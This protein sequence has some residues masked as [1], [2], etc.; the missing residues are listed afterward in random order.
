MPA[1]RAIWTAWALQGG[2]R[3][4]A[5]RGA[6]HTP[7]RPLV[8]LVVASSWGHLLPPPSPLTGTWVSVDE[9]VCWIIS[10]LPRGQTVHKCFPFLNLESALISSFPRIHHSM[11]RSVSSSN[12]K[13]FGSFFPKK[14]KVQ[15]PKI[16]SFY[17]I[18][19][20][21]NPFRKNNDEKLSGR[22]VI[23]WKNDFAAYEVR[24][25]SELLNVC[26]EI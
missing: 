11:S 12:V 9:K 13:I 15:L 23:L 16:K 20:L 19:W 26:P 10:V 5:G 17:N 6:A 25:T 2:H 7:P 3:G 14:K 1:Q 4:G 8:P 22:E 21:W 18:I 24:F